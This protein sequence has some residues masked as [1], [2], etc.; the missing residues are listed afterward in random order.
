MNVIVPP[1]P[2]GVTTAIFFTMLV[3]FLLGFIIEYVEIIFI[4]IPIAGPPLMELGVDPVWF[5]ILI[6]MNLQMSFLTPPFGYALFYFRRVAPEEIR[7]AD[8]YRGI[9]PFVCLQLV[10]LAGVALF[11]ALATWLPAVIYD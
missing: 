8:I 4:V 5:A 2:G 1:V 3:I 6:S 7:T 10:A 9:V 11:P